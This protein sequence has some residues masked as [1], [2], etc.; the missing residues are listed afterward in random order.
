MIADVEP[1]LVT[2]VSEV[3]TKMLDLPVTHEPLM[4]PADP[5]EFHVAGAV[6]FIG[7]SSGVVYLYLHKT[8]ARRLACRLLR[9]EDAELESEAMVND[10][11][12][13]L[14]NMVVGQVKSQ[15]EDRGHTFVL[16]IPSIVRGSHFTIEPVS[17]TERLVMH[18]QTS[19][20][21]LLLEVL[22]KPAPQAMAA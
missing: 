15:L 21:L 10:A 5:G 12:G 3:F 8:L 18:F 7:A 14:A 17:T 6:G 1:L 13:E 20:G 19:E 4:D 22:F 16:T 2:A 9:I 11:I